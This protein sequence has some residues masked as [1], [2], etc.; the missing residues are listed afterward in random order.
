MPTITVPEAV[1]ERLARRAQALGTSVEA[2]TLPAIEAVAADPPRGALSPE[3]EWKKAM[4]ELA[5][6]ARSR[7]HRY[8]PGFQV[9]D[10]RESIYE[11]CGE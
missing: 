11:G 10:S 9:D 8:P 6:S 4:A 2:L 3:T 7:V 1:Y 5:A